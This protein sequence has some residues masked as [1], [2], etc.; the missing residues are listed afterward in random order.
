MRRSPGILR[1]YALSYRRQPSAK[2]PDLVKRVQRSS[3]AKDYAVKRLQVIDL[4]RFFG[5]MEA[6]IGQEL[7]RVRLMGWV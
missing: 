1:W 3:C 4:Q 5:Y 2:M 7:H 6:R